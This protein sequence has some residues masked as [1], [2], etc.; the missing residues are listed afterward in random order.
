MKLAKFLAS[1]IFFAVVTNVSATV[2]TYEIG[3]QSLQIPSPSGYQEVRSVAP[4]I[5]ALGASLTPRDNRLIAMFVS[6][7]DVNAAAKGREPRLDKYYLVQTL[8]NVEGKELSEANF[9][10]VQGVLKAQF[11]AA[12]KQIAPEIQ[13][14]IESVSKSSEFAERLGSQMQVGQIIGLEVFEEARNSISWLTVTKLRTTKKGRVIDYAVVGAMTTVY[15]KGQLLAMYVCSRLRAKSDFDW[16]KQ[17][18]M[19]WLK[20][21]NAHN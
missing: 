5:Y 3:G 17:Q 10:E 6:N 1:L 14:L 21:I 16:V 8:R 12:A 9:R 4:H 20:A 2:P 11:Q 7:E 19:T 15:V 18:S 13:A